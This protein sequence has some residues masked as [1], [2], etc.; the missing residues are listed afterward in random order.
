VTE[1]VG[2]AQ[3]EADQ[4]EQLALFQNL[5]SDREEFFEFVAE[6]ERLARSAADDQMTDRATLFRA[7]HTLKA[8]CAMRG[9]GSI[10]SVCHVLERK[11]AQP[12]EGL[13]AIDRER[14]AEVWSA[15]LERVRKLTGE[16]AEDRVELARSDL[17]SM[18]DAMEAGC[19]HAELLQMLRRLDREPAAHRL[20]RLAE[21][22][23]ALAQRLGKGELE[24]TIQ[25]DDVRFDRKRWAPFWSSFVHMLRNAVDHGI[26]SA[27]ERLAMGK[28]KLGQ[29]SL[30]VRQIDGEVVIEISDDGRGIDWAGVRQKARILG[31]QARTEA[32]LLRTLLRGGVSTKVAVT[33]I[34]GRGAGVSAC[35]RACDALGGRLSLATAPGQGT[36]FSFHFPADRILSVEFPGRRSLWRTT[37]ISDESSVLVEVE[38]AGGDRSRPSAP[39][40]ARSWRGGRDV[41]GLVEG[42][43]DRSGEGLGRADAP[44]VQEDDAR[45]LI[46][47]VVVD[48]DDV[49]PA[50]AQGL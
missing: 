19:N 25:S 2:L 49:D 43:F 8:I 38:D 42:A 6:C 50:S 13:D 34:S 36:T 37:E 45:V 7:V 23:R 27:E 1:A 15:F 9:V 31:Y 28:P 29:L 48:G 33:E 16:I 41:P 18:A 46:G 4:R 12:G 5:V 30:R 40:R 17:Q 24:V 14:L 22:A 32:E 10:A 20:E 11:L 39:W 44:E 35:G 3:S 21:D 26:E 47:H